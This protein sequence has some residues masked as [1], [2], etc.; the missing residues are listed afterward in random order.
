MYDEGPGSAA[1]STIETCAIALRPTGAQREPASNVGVPASVAP[2]SEGTDPAE[3]V[4]VA[5]SDPA[6]TEAAASDAEEASV[7]GVPAASTDPASLVAV[8]P[9]RAANPTLKW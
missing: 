4:P 3:S 9:G 6:T 2:A 5:A 1:A 8:A 7:L